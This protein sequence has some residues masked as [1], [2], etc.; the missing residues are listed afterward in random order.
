M[1]LTFCTSAKILPAFWMKVFLNFARGMLY[2]K[3]AFQ[4]LQNTVSDIQ[5]M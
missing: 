3:S 5:I 2:K 4:L 1:I